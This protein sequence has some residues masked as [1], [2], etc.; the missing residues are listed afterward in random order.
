V[1]TA[2]VPISF[3]HLVGATEQREGSVIPGV[4]A[5]LKVNDQLDV[6]GLLHRPVSR[7]FALEPALLRR[8]QMATLAVVA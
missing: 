6:S 5:V 7:F 8:M 1:P 4:L 3:D 2:E